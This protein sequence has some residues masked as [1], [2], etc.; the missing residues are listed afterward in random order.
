LLHQDTQASGVASATPPAVEPSHD[1][2]PAAAAHTLVAEASGARES[3]G[4]QPSMGIGL[5]SSGRMPPPVIPTLLG[6]DRYV[7]GMKSVTDR[8][9]RGGRAPDA[10]RCAMRPEGAWR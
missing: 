5:G 1:D 4:K 6:A 7:M 9:L 8:E 10:T 3:T 2:G